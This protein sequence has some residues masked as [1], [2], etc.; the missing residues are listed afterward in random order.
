VVSHCLQPSKI[1]DVNC[2][3]DFKYQQGYFFASN[4]FIFDNT[5]L[6]WVYV[7]LD[8]QIQASNDISLVRSLLSIAT[9]PIHCPA[10]G[11]STSKSLLITILPLIQTPIRPGRVCKARGLRECNDN[12][13]AI[14]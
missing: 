4:S 11:D 12:Q 7:L 2:V 3:L 1:N 9:S 5:S 14:T 6:K 8:T 13:Y 10:L